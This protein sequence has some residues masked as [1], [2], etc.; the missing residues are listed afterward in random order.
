MYA[1]YL[2]LLKCL[3]Q[4]QAV[5]SGIGKNKFVCNVRTD[6]IL[7]K[8]E[9]AKK[10]LINVSIMISK[11]DVQHAI[12]VIRYKMENA[13]NCRMTDVRFDKMVFASNVIQ[14]IKSKVMN[15]F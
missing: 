9:N 1:L 5:K 6:G 4:I 12:K 7:V 11:E 2:F 13:I 15:V 3:H 10:Y 14:V 8:K